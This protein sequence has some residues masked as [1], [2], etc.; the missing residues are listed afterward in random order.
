M[1]P[2]LTFTPA[3]ADLPP[4]TDLDAVLADLSDDHVA[5]PSKDV[6]ALVAVVNDAKSKDIE[7]SVVVVENNPIRDAQLRDL[8]TEVGE[9]EGGT[10]LVL[11][12]SWV[13][14]FSGSIDRVTLEAGQDH[15]YTG[16]A[17]TASQNFLAEITKPAM[18]WTEVTCVILAGTIAATAGLYAVKVRRARSAPPVSPAASESSVSG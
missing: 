16:N 15:T 4:N 18:P 11:S 13:G 14:T 12:P 8:A 3:A 6:D 9:H 2:T 17:V 1:S 10:V 5:A 7:L